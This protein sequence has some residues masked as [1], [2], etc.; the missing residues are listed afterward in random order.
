MT[1]GGPTLNTYFLIRDSFGNLLPPYARGE[2]VIAGA[3]VGKGY[4]N[5][6]EM[7]HEKFIKVKINGKD[8]PAYR[9]GDIA[10]FNGKGEIV[11][12]GRNDN[13]V[14]IRGLRV[15][16]DGIENVMSSFPGIKRSV[17]LVKGTGDGSF[18]CG[19]YVAE[20]PVDE[21]KLTA[22]MKETLTEYMIP[23]V[24]VHLTELPLTTTLEPP[25]VELVWVP[26]SS[27]LSSVVRPENEVYSLALLPL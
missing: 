16:L 7:T 23:G 11:H 3:Q 25:A 9:S 2:L 6:D 13:Q 19:Y 26:W 5:L 18:L 14:K 22:H 12:C 20:Q 1:I 10:Y 24:F 27:L 15:E 4:V 17:V 21:A 8:I